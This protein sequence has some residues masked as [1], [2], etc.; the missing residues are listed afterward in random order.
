VNGDGQHGRWAYAMAR[1]V[2]EIHGILGGIT[3]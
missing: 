2:G 3:G 1:A